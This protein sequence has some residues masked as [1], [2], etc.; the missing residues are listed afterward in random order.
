MTTAANHYDQMLARHYSWMLG[1]DITARAAEQARLLESLGITPAT[2]G[3]TAID[4]GC[5][6]GDQAL[7]LAALGF[8]RVLAVDT[9]SVLLDELAAHAG[10]DPAIQPINADLRT[11]LHRIAEPGGTAVIVCM[12]DTLTHLPD[13]RDVTVLL[14]HAKQALAEGGALVITYRDLTRPLRGTDRFIP[15]RQSPDQLLTCF[16]EYL[17]DDTVLVHDLLHIRSGGTW[18]QQVGSYPK[19]RLAP[20]WLADQCRAAGLDIQRNEVGP[21]GMR[22]LHARKP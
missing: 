8:T 19:L 9:S 12:G 5:G 17:D 13:K 1:G 21:G 2:A 16:L 3:A 11:V 22:L 10:D 20:G 7:A 18:T 14:G 6:P 4:L 15:V